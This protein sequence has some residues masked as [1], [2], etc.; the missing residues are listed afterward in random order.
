VTNYG[1]VV[2]NTRGRRNVM[3][4]DS[5]LTLVDIHDNVYEIDLKRL[6]KDSIKLIADTV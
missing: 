6:D 4:M 1:E 3:L 5:K 2:V